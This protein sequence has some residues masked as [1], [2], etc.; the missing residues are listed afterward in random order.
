MKIEN[1]SS[2]IKELRLKENLTQKQ[3]AKKIFVSDKVIS[4]WENGESYPNI[5]NI[6]DLANVFDIEIDDLVDNKNL[7]MK[8]ARKSE[9]NGIRKRKLPYNIFNFVIDAV[10]LSFI[11]YMFIR[12]WLSYDSLPNVIGIHFNFSGVIDGYGSKN[13][14][15]ISPCVSLGL[16]LIL[17][18]LQCLRI[19]WYINIGLPVPLE[20][21]AVNEK[22]ARFIY[23]TFSVGLSLMRLFFTLMM[24]DSFLSMINQKFTKIIIFGVS[25][26]LFVLTPIIGIALCVVKGN[27][28]KRNMMIEEIQI[29]NE[30]NVEEN[31]TIKDED[32]INE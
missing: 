24:F 23:I 10:T 25:I 21:V 7:A 4:K 3:L 26:T 29:K 16:S 20:S 9:K 13:L 22:H 14:L 12:I 30:K 27:R 17:A 5:D 6:V 15:F 28:E 2:K 18:I 19:R 11:L 1:M 8:L 32:D 31:K